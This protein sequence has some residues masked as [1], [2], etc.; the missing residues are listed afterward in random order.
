MRNTYEVRAQKFIRRIAK[1]LEGAQEVYD[2][3]WGVKAYNYHYH[4]K[5]KLDYGM[6]RVALITSDY[7]VKIDYNKTP[8]GNCE[9]E[10]QVYTEATL[11]GFSYLFAKITRYEYN[12]IS[13]YIMPR[14]HGIGRTPYDAEEYLTAEEN[15]WVYEHLFDL[16]NHNYG[17][18]KNKIIIFDYAARR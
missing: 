12:G 16:H 18:Y 15:D 10:M 4:T 2:F 13:F 1:Y 5:V 6:S 11:D 14:I 9:D 8:W 3:Q 17:W 7:V